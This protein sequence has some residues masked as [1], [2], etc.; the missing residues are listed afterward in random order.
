MSPQFASD[1]QNT[2]ASASAF[3]ASLVAQMVKNFPA[4]LENRLRSLS[5]KDLLEKG[6]ATHTPVFL[7]REFHGQRNLAGY[8]P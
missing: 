5:W 2:G 6:M 1:D 4:V 3:R 8:S 7:P